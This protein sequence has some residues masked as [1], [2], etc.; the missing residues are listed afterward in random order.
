MYQHLRSLHT[1]RTSLLMTRI[2]K[3]CLKS[4]IP[5]CSEGKLTSK[6][7]S[8]YEASME[9]KRKEMVEEMK[10]R[11]LNVALIARNMNS[12]F[13]LR[14]KELIEKEPAVK[15]T[16]ER[17][18]ALF[19]HS[20]IMAEFNRISGKNLQ[21]EFFQKLDR[22]TPRFIDIFRAKGGDIGS[23]LK[24]ILQ[25]IEN[26]KSNINAGRT[27]VLH[28]LPL[29]LGEDPS[30]FYKTCFDCD[31]NEDMS[32]IEIGILTVIPEGSA[33]VPYSLHLGATTTAII[34]EE[35]TDQ[36]HHRDEVYPNLEAPSYL[37]LKSILRFLDIE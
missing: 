34:L 23:K 8:S 3:I 28:G 25:Q 20:Q 26:D 35:A 13:A 1:N 2:L 37:A 14:R 16:V 9:S 22:F 18:P 21:T 27:A 7:P 19:T 29:L 5:E 17:W 36:L 24:K 31:D 6:Y 30:D 12:T 32:D 4:G 15:N 11:R 10:K 33:T